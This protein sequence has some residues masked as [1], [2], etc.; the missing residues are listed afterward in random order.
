MNVIDPV[1]V[2]P[3]MLVTNVPLTEPGATNWVV[4][5]YGLGAKV[6]KARHVWESLA[7]ANTAEPGAETTTPLKW[8]DLGAINAWRMFD[9]GAAVLKGD[10]GAQVRVYKIGTTTTNPGT[11]DF[12]ITPGRVISGVALFGL[13]GYRA[14]VTMTDPYD[15]VVRSTTI[16]LVDASSKGMWEWLFKPTRRKTTFALLDLPAYGTASIRVVIEADVGGTATCSMASL[17]QLVEVGTSVFGT[18]PGITDFSTREVDPFGNENMI[19][20]GYRDRVQFD[21]RIISDDVSYHLEFLKRLRARGAVYIGDPARQET[22]IFGRYRD[23]QI[24]ISNPAISE[25]ALD[26]GSLV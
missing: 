6:I 24:V 12:T 19:E 13:S 17:G 23:L 20:R 3:A 15:G 18:A 1:E 26:V 21:V 14:T 11:I 2:T 22:I 25:C 16:S 4:G 10:S 5:S 9:K 7:A 8:L